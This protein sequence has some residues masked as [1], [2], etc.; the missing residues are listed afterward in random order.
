MRT[1]GIDLGGTKTLA[2]LVEDGVVVEKAKRPTPRVGSPD[3]VLATMAKVAASVDP[4]AT[5]TAIGIGAPGP[6][7]PG[8]G[9]LPAA[10][11]LPGW[12]HDVPVADLMSERLGERPVV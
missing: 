9:V 4:D 3:D 8:T 10:P 6:V 1:I 7:V 5:A 11:N 2:V 12:D